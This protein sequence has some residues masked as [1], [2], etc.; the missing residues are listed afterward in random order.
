MTAKLPA[1]FSQTGGA[2]VPDANA[3]ASPSAL[4]IY[5]EFSAPRPLPI[6]NTVSIGDLVEEFSADPGMAAAI[7]TARQNLA[8]TLYS[9]E[10]DSL[11][12][13]RLLAGLSQSQLAER[14][15]TSQSHIARIEAGQTDPSTDVISRIAKSINIDD[16]VA[17]SAIRKQ[18][19]TR[20]N[21][22]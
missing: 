1:E 9:D 13:L 22:K 11:S 6:S 20:G 5:R 16:G 2:S 14:V 10:I 8:K 12:A 17:F 3:V 4:V 15:G 19:L 7:V 18:L 21:E